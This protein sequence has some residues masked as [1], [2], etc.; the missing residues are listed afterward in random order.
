MIFGS[1]PACAPFVLR[2]VQTV[3]TS[4]IGRGSEVVQIKVRGRDRGVP[5]PGLDGYRINS[6]GQPQACG[7]VA[8][9]VDASALGNSGPSECPLEGGGV[10][11]V[12]HNDRLTKGTRGV[13]A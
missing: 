5:H 3:Q 4:P 1:W 8:Q 9:V 7:R 2:G 10:K 11:L 6:A 12:Y 13:V